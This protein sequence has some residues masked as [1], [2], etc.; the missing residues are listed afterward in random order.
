MSV[1]VFLSLLIRLSSF[2]HRRVIDQCSVLSDRMATFKAWR[3]SKWHLKIRIRPQRK[4]T[5]SLLKI[6][7]WMAFRKM[8]WE[9][10]E[11][12]PTNRLG[13]KKK[14]RYW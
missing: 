4:H 2:S 8:K 7:L 11:T 13:E 3:S 10:D 9:R 5:A 12:K 1:F 14:S 6:I